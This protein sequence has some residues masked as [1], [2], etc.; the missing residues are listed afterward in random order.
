MISAK[1]RVLVHTLRHPRR[2]ATASPKVHEC[3]AS[4]ALVLLP[5]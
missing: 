3:A 4:S 2:R 5:S 1:S